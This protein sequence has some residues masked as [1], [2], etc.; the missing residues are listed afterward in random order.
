MHREK[1]ERHHSNGAVSPSLSITFTLN[2]F[3][4]TWN[5]NPVP[6]HHKS[7]TFSILLWG[8]TQWLNLKYPLRWCFWNLT[9]H[10]G[11]SHWTFPSRINRSTRAELHP[12]P[13]S[14]VGNVKVSIVDLF[15]RF[16]S[17]AIFDLICQV[18]IGAL[19]PVALRLMFTLFC[20]LNRT[21]PCTCCLNGIMNNHWS[22]RFSCFQMQN[23]QTKRSLTFKRIRFGSI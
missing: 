4:E 5:D 23:A 3:Q 9:H 2:K 21:L 1:P 22:R 20:P 14:F 16:W 15:T 12:P 8:A 17:C 13:R 6:T 11:I 10:H 7:V 18:L 19:R